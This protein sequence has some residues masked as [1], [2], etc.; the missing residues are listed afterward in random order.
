MMAKEGHDPASFWEADFL[1]GT[2]ASPGFGFQ[3][4]PSPNS[5]NFGDVVTNVRNATMQQMADAFRTRILQFF[6]GVVCE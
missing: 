3:R 1:G 5:Q 4:C 2:Y 6:L